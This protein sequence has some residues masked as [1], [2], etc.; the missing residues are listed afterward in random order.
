MAGSR[1]PGITAKAKST[2]INSGSS[3]AVVSSLRGLWEER[4]LQKA[5][6]LAYIETAQMPS[7][8]DRL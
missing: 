7:F 6:A 2:F 1:G 5:S 3:S 4:R 8:L